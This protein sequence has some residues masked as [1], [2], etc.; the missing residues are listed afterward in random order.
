MADSA[1]QQFA[2]MPYSSKILLLAL[3]LVLIGA[4]Y[5]TLFHSPLTEQIEQT[6]GQQLQLREQLKQ[7]N[8]LQ[9]KFLALREELETRKA[10]E[11]Q[12]LRILPPR[13]EIASMLADLNRLAELSG[14]SIESVEPRPEMEAPYYYKI[15][16]T[17]RLSGRYHQLAKFFYNVSRL[18]RAINMESISIGQPTYVGE[19]LI[20]NVGVRATAFRRKDA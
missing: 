10:S 9:A 6:Q 5:Y 7:A 15:P 2:K 18:Q 17:L 13:A 14:L 8:D 4:G 16:V 3:L 11:Q 12:L 20:L 1:A 19:D